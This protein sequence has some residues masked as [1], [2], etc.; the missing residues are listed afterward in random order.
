MLAGMWLLKQI[1]A[2]IAILILI[3]ILITRLLV[4][5]IG[6]VWKRR[7]TREIFRRGLERAG[8]SP[9]DADVFADQCYAGISFRELLRLRHRFE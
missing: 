1:W 3:P 9:D 4:V 2:C 5:A 8:L 7:R 6:V